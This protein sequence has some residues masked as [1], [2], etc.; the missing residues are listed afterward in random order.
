MDDTEN[1]DAILDLIIGIAQRIRDEGY[2]YAEYASPVFRIKLLA[3]ILHKELAKHANDN[4]QKP[5]D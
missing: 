4:A 5:S 3:D 2:Q 1:L